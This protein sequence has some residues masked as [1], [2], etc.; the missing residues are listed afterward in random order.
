MRLAAGN[1]AEIE[2]RIGADGEVG[3]ELAVPGQALAPAEEGAVNDRGDEVSK[4]EDAFQPL[5]T[6]SAAV[7]DRSPAQRFAGRIHKQLIGADA[8]ILGIG[9]QELD[10]LFDRI[11]S[12]EII[13]TGL[14]ADDFAPSQAKSLV[15][16]IHF[17]LVGFGRKRRRG[18]AAA[19]RWSRDTESSL[20][21]PLMTRH[22]RRR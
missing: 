8:D 15:R 3:V 18:S 13:I 1:D 7:G 9:K 10:G 17:T 21:P 2:F 20:E 4:N 16:G 22:S 19:N 14:N 6:Q 12:A 5:G 11:R